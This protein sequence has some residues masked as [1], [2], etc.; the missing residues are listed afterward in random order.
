MQHV[1]SNWLG[2]LCYP[3]VFNDDDS[4]VISHHNQHFEVFSNCIP[5]T[6]ILTTFSVASH[7]PIIKTA[8]YLQ[9]TLQH[10]C[11]SKIFEK[12]CSLVN[13]R[14][15]KVDM[16][17][18]W[19]S[20]SLVIQ[21]HGDSKHQAEPINQSFVSAINAA[22][23]YKPLVDPL[24]LARLY[25]HMQSGLTLPPDCLQ[26]CMLTCISNIMVFTTIIVTKSVQYQLPRQHVTTKKFARTSNWQT[27]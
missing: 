5:Y 14:L 19:P 3:T 27:H 2:R 7:W 23:S 10:S 25:N 21:V 26:S 15:Q 6:I 13:T 11:T 16:S 4:I 17:S 1:F 12:R 24:R 22:T 8:E 18:L 20:L 9:F